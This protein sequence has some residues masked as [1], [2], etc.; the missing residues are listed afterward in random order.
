MRHLIIAKN[1]RYFWNHCEDRFKPED[2]AK[3]IKNQGRLILKNG[4]ELVYIS[5]NE[6]L[7]GHHGVQV[8]MWSMPEW[9]D[10]EETEALARLAR[11][12]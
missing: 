12:P 11:M 4:D 2:V 8:H 6:K 7:R 1:L 3:A 10:A 5:S 9:F